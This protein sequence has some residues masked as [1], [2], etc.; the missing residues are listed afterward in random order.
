MLRTIAK[1]A[2]EICCMF[3]TGSIVGGIADRELKKQPSKFKRLLGQ[4][5]VICL[6]AIAVDAGMQ[7]G[8][9]IVDRIFDFCEVVVDGTSKGEEHEGNHTEQ[10]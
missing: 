7:K 10:S 9:E 8:D 4:G 1:A 2:L 5:A 3:G 6:T